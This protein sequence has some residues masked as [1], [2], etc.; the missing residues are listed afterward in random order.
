MKHAEPTESLESGPNEAGPELT[1]AADAL[2]LVA[3][4]AMWVG[5][6]W[7][8][9]LSMG[10]TT[11]TVGVVTL[12]ALAGSY[13]WHMASRR[14]RR[15][16]AEYV[17]MGL[18]IGTFLS[19][20]CSQVAVGTRLAEIA[21]AIPVGLAALHR[22][23]WPALHGWAV[24]DPPPRRLGSRGHRSVIWRQSLQSVWMLP[25]AM[26][27]GLAVAIPLM[28]DHPINWTGWWQFHKDFQFHEAVAS[29]VHN[30]GT[31]TSGWFDASP[32]RYHWFV[33]SWSGTLTDAAD[34]PP[35]AA[36]T[37]ATYLVAITGAACLAWSWAR[38]I[39]TLPLVWGLSATLLV[40][41]TY[42][43]VPMSIGLSVGA[44][45]PAQAMGLVWMLG[46][47]FAVT[48][49]FDGVLRNSVGTVIVALLAMATTGGKV[50]HGAVLAG[51]VWLATLWTAARPHLRAMLW[52]SV[53]MTVAV[54]LGLLAGYVYAISGSRGGGLTVRFN[55]G[56][57]EVLGLVDAPVIG[58]LIGLLAVGLA[59]LPRAI[60]LLA[61]GRESAPPDFS[62]ILGVGMALTGFLLFVLVDQSGRSQDHFLLSATSAVAVLSAASLGSQRCNGRVADTLPARWWVSRVGIGVTVGI[63]AA[64][65][66]YG[67]DRLRLPGVCLLAAPLVPWF[68]AWVVDVAGGR[69]HPT[70]RWRSV[71]LVVSCASI[72]AGLLYPLQLVIGTNP[73]RS[74][75]PSAPEQ[76]LALTMDY[77]EGGAWVREHV[78]SSA[79]FVTNRMCSTPTD[80][81]PA[82]ESLWYLAS[83]V[84]ARQFLV[85]GFGYG[86]D[87]ADSELAA[88]VALSLQ[89][90]NEPNARVL[91]ELE[92][93]AVEYLWVD[94]AA[95]HTPRLG[96]HFDLMFANDSVEVYRIP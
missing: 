5:V 18:A 67:I 79:S 57:A 82:C 7:W 62:V 25:V 22:A 64:I 51:G 75:G 91:E 81:P 31:R 44:A 63:A 74:A 54:T 70:E 86:V 10:Q 2:V 52:L 90:T 14:N 3:A 42:V 60:G 76:R 36:L 55:A 47:V 53:R 27:L 4:F 13:I 21:W 94:L 1:G 66:Y 96:E 69:R 59:V 20:L 17:G 38:S 39:T 50:N 78:P 48:R 71:V 19:M 65:T 56:F 89:A 37:R 46:A 93:R 61:W 73:D 29:S 43:G 58:A 35:F 34:L 88:R 9:D 85:E 77:L 95:V 32:V 87:A 6:L 16:A 84:T 68:G 41:G 12:Q 30:L 49:L 45:A 72:A 80:T 40:A 11:R 26:V 24:N 83:A 28:L 33:H 8:S 23:T 15:P 92:N